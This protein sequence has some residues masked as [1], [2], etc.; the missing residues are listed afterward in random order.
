VP[1]APSGKSGHVRYKFLD[2][3]FNL[4]NLVG[5][6]VFD[7]E[8]QFPQGG[9][10]AAVTRRTRRHENTAGYASLTAP[11]PV[12]EPG[13]PVK[14]KPPDEGPEVFL[15]SSLGRQARISAKV[16]FCGRARADMPRHSADRGRSE[17]VID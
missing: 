1:G 17:A 6:V 15:L 9:L 10:G 14:Q 16:I 13:D 4:C 5:R 2:P 7:H 11:C 3:R 8:I 12:L